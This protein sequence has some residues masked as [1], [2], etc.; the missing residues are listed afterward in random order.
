MKRSDSNLGEAGTRRALLELLKRD[1]EQ[2]A[3]RLAAQL[4][5]TA[6]AVRQHLY[7]LADEGLVEYRDEPRPLGR[8]AKLWRLTSAAD[9]FFPDAHA[10]LTVALI[11]SLREALGEDGIEQV[12][13]ARA[14]T[15]TDGYRR[16][17]D[18]AATL[19]G[20]L[21]ALARIRS[22]EGY[23]ASVERAED[24]AYYLLENHCPICVAATACQGICRIEQAV[25]QA[26]LGNDVTVERT[27]H[28]LAGARRC[29]YRVAPKA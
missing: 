21:N 26:V 12:L 3:A 4:G 18:G 15:L 17:L 6:M 23:M 8:P 28:I 13:A 27:E 10:D 20:R 19:R 22:E 16:R 1:G 25:F 24:G 7:A 9:R 14:K 29:A 11:G 5:I 2:D